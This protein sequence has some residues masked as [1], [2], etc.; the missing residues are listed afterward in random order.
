[1]CESDKTENLVTTGDMTYAREVA[2]L[3]SITVW[4]YT[5]S[6]IQSAY[7]LSWFELVSLLS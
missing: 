1:M 5:S 2:E 6:L 4:V 7:F 3:T